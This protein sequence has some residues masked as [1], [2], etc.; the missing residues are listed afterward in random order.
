MEGEMSD[1][2]KVKC[3]ECGIEARVDIKNQV[4]RSFAISEDE[5]ARKCKHLEE[6]RKRF[7]CPNIQL[8]L[9]NLANSML[10]SGDRR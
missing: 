7:M 4:M 2:D 9:D 3:E 6:A 5:F 10:P 1:Q 8:A